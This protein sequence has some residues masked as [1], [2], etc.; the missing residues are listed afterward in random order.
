MRVALHVLLLA[1]CA[2]GAA[3]AQQTWALPDGRAYVETTGSGPERR[4]DTPPWPVEA[5][6]SGPTDRYGHDVLGG[7]PR[8]SVLE[9]RALTCGACRH[10]SEG[11]KIALPEDMVFEDVAP[12]LWDVDGDGRPEI[13]TVESHIRRGARLAIW[14]YPITPSNGG[15]LTRI[16]ATPFIGQANRWLAPAGIGDFDGDGRVEIAYVD[17]PHLARELVFVRLEGAALRQIARAPGFSNHRIGDT[18]ITSA[19]R[20]CNGRDSLVLPSAAWDQVIEVTLSGQTVTTTP[21]GPLRAPADV[22]A[23][24]AC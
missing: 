22:T 21:R 1:L 14:A 7:I 10:G 16:A 5:R 3:D 23:A 24:L 8:W 19:T 4:D 11:A 18:A 9:V 15:D 6:L 17:R 20:T 12:R 13:V 2:C